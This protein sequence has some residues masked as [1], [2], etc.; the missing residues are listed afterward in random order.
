MKPRFAALFFL[1]ATTL[2]ALASS[3]AGAQYNSIHVRREGK[4]VFYKASN[5]G[6]ELLTGVPY[7]DLKCGKCHGPTYADGTPVDDASY[8]PGSC[9][10]CH[11]GYQVP[12]PGAC[13]KCHSRQNAEI[14]AD[15]ADASYADVHR[16]GDMTCTDCHGEAELHADA[17]TRLSMLDPSPLKPS[18]A[19]CHPTLSATYSH[20]DHA[21]TLD[22]TACHTRTVQTCYNCHFETELAT[23]GGIKRPIKQLRN[24][25]ML[26]N[27]DGKVQATTYMAMTYDGKAFFTLAP[28]V[29]HSIVREGKQCADC[30]NNARVQEYNST[31]SIQMTTWNAA[32]SPPTIV[33]TTGVVPI[34]PDWRTALKFDF[35]D[36][37]GDPATATD[38]TKWIFLKSTPD[39][40]QMLAQYATPLT[41][42]QMAALLTPVSVEDDQTGPRTPGLALRATPNPFRGEATLRFELTRPTP[43]T[44]AVYDVAGRQVAKLIDGAVMPAGAHS[45]RFDGRGLPAGTYLCRLL[46][47]GHGTFTRIVLTH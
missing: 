5:G 40:T 23:G 9:A 3:D 19:G 20:T 7:A 28:Y 24:C 31:G 17:G 25:V 38:P 46:A 26:S 13:L 18:C 12:S 34:P 8:A 21:A 41:Q 15:N 44:L 1:L 22:C 30:H 42:A 29:S 39:T 47:D 37:T 33:G 36:Y 45:A 16:A 6:F 2:L 4:D 32:A 10:D 27:R 14:N 11:A 43:V 35:V